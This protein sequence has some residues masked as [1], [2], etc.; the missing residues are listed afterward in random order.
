MLAILYGREKVCELL[1]SR[2]AAID[3]QG[4]DGRTVLMIAISGQDEDIVRLLLPRK[5]NVNLRANNG[6]TALSIAKRKLPNFVPLLKKAG[7]VEGGVV[8]KRV[9]RTDNAKSPM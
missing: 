1:L 4:S 8:A 6:E 5:A 2:G 3:T 9:N 7:A